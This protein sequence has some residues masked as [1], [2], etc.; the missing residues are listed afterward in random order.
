LAHNSSNSYEFS[1]LLLPTQPHFNKC[2]SKH[3][4]IHGWSGQPDCFLKN[5]MICTPPFARSCTGRCLQHVS[6]FPALSCTLSTRCC[7]RFNPLSSPA[8]MRPRSHRCR[9]H[10][11]N[12][13]F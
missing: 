6:T 5:K 4:R 10:A 8:T 2:W 1:Q 12:M 11:F 9:L 7:W 13:F 3:E